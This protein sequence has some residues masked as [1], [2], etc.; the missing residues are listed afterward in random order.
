[1]N[2]PRA[3]GAAPDAI[4]GYL[5]E[6]LGRLTVGR[7]RVRRVIAEAEDHLRES[8]TA[9]EAAGLDPTAAQQA[10]IAD[11]GSPATVARRFAADEGVLLP[12]SMLLHLFLALA[13]MGS[14]GFAAIGVSGLVAAGMGAVAGQRFVAG[15][16]NGVT[17]TS[18]RCADFQTYY[19]GTCEEAATAHH[20]DEVVQY[21]VVAGVLGLIG[22]GSLS[23]V[24]RAF[25][26]GSGVR[27]LPATFFP[28]MAT[29]LFG[30]AAAGLLVQSL[31]QFMVAGRIPGEEA[32]IGAVLSG[33]LV[34]LVAFAAYGATLVRRLR[35]A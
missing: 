16:H 4:D 25:P 11:F 22:L 32:G 5:D 33:G 20:F 18:A 21:R 34:S 12:P 8:A 15:D 6:L 7:D 28:T 19:P 24:R 29:A 35:A 1:M 14:V 30:I 31:G 10:A 17:Y 27:L 26:R 23:L 3:A 13:L 2:N 9:H